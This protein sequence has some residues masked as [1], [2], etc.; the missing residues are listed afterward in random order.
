LTLTVR[1]RGARADLPLF[2]V[3]HPEVIRSVAPLV[4]SCTLGARGGGAALASGRLS[5]DAWTLATPGRRA[6]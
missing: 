3:L 2:G 5:E 6:M 1:R 4:D